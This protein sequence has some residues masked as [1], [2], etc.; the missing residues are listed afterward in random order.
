MSDPAERT[1]QVNTGPLAGLRVIE[2]GQLL[3]GPYVG[4]LLGDFGA[5]VIKVE[6]PDKGDPMRDWGR[7]RNN[8][9]SLWWS[10]VGRNKRSVGINLRTEEG[11]QLA[12]KLCESADIIVENFRPGTME[13][14]NLGP[15]HIHAVNPK[16]IYARISGYGQSGRYRDRAGFASAGEAVGGLRY[17]NG[18]PDQAPPRSGISLGD[19]LAAQS[20]FQGILLALYARDASGIVQGQVV[21][22]AITD[23]CFAMLE[24]TVL[25]Y[26]KCGVVR[27]PT[28]P[29]LPRIAPSNV[30]KSKDGKWVV[31]AANHDSL[32]RRL[33]KAMGK[34]E[35]GD[36]PRYSTH[37][38]RGENEDYLDEVIGEWAGQLTAA[39]IDKILDEHGVVCSPVYSA[40]DIYKDDYFRERELLV[41]HK[42]DVH[43]E[44]SATGVVPKLTAT[45][46]SIRASARWVVGVDTG[47]ILEELGVPDDERKALI[48]AGI[49]TD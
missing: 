5:E 9:H 49:V 39:E 18:H 11:Q 32:W 10:M 29:R 24:S 26:E 23:A 22:A 35:M 12:R 30:Y 2:F 16:C 27:E 14:W 17:I 19:T 20:A 3:A 15:E 47:S 37:N 48:A 33:A 7:L 31:I 44:M 43:G 36:D 42:D 25:E 34:E 1:P 21:D 6:Q 40:E 8:G 28:G 45:P 38:A 46:G 41:P 4:T 13:R